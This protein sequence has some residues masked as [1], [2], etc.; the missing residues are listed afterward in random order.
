MKNEFD[1]YKEKANAMLDEMNEKTSS[2]M[3]NLMDSDGVSPEQSEAANKVVYYMHDM[4]GYAI[5]VAEYCN[6]FDQYKHMGEEDALDFLNR[7][8]KRSLSQMESACNVVVKFLNIAAP[9][10]SKERE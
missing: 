6:N 5:K 1:E 3:R 2:M 9:G 8:A 10:N 7:S 4:Q